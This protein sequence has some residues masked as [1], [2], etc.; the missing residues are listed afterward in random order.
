MEFRWVQKTDQ[1]LPYDCR[2]RELHTVI[3]GERALEWREN[4][5]KPWTQAG[6]IPV[7]VV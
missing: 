5:E 4:E 7:V 2:G 3:L 1:I 6:K